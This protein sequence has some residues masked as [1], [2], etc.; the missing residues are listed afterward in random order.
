LIIDEA[1]LING[2][3]SSSANTSRK[4][5]PSQILLVLSACITLSRPTINT[6]KPVLAT[7]VLHSN[8][9]SKDAAF[10]LE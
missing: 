9:V 10:A 8:V 2:Y 1:T 5:T 4:Q 3:H 6:L 7:V